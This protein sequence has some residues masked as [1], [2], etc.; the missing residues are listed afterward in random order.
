MI[1]LLEYFFFSSEGSENREP[2]C[3]E[4]EPKPGGVIQEGH[5]LWAGQ[6]GCFQG[7]WDWEGQLVYLQRMRI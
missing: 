2:D 7:G 1:V 4:G 3:P 5:E 6:Q